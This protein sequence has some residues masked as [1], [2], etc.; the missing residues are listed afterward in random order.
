MVKFLPIRGEL[1]IA[2]RGTRNQDLERKF[3]TGKDIAGNPNPDVIVIMAGTNDV[4]T[5]L[6]GLDESIYYLF[7]NIEALFPDRLKIVIGIRII[8]KH[9]NWTLKIRNK[10]TEGRKAINDA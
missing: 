2:I 1:S 5:C 7:K 6:E 4:G 10:N 3:L 8:P 9:H